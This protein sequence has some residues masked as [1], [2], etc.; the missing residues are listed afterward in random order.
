MF[1]VTKDDDFV[2]VSAGLSKRILAKEPKLFY[3]FRD[4]LSH[5]KKLCLDVEFNQFPE[6]Y[7]IISNTKEPHSATWKFKIIK[8]EE[9]ALVVEKTKSLTSQK[10]RGKMEETKEVVTDTE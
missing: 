6:E 2:M 4:A 1:E 8:K 7:F 10:K 3:S 9:P 5:A